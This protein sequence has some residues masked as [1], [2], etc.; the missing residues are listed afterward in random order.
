MAV[1]AM[2]DPE[3]AENTYRQPPKQ[4]TAAGTRRI[5]R[6]IPLM[7]LNASPVWNS[8][9]PIRMN[10]GMGVNEKLTTDTTLLRTNLEESGLAAEK[11]P[12]TDDVDSDER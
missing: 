11:Q 6:S 4:P 3:K 1:V 5:R 10:N 9:S 12:G 8:T 2:V 7:T